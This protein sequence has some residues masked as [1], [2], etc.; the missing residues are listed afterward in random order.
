VTQAD[1][2]DVDAELAGINGVLGRPT[3]DTG[4]LPMPTEQLPCKR[5]TQHREVVWNDLRLSFERGFEGAN[6]GAWNLGPATVLAPVNPFPLQGE[7][8]LTT[9]AGVGLGSSRSDLAVYEATL[10]NDDSF[11][12]RSGPFSFVSFDLVD[13]RVVSISSGPLD[14]LDPDEPR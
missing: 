1:V 7:S 3:G 11:I 4:W 13:D 5:D 6:L 14:C 12:V 10:D 9:L 8:N 2:I